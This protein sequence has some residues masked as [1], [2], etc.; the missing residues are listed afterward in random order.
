MGRRRNER[1]VRRRLGHGETLRQS[2]PLQTSHQP[3]PQRNRGL[4]QIDEH[5]A[6]LLDD[7]L[8]GHLF[9]FRSR[10]RDRVKLLVSVRRNP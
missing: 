7:P 4:R 10:R 5:A 9:V 8:S 6:G 3:L 2:P 1:L